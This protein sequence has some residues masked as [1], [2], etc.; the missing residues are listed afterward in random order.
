MTLISTASQVFGDCP[1]TGGG[2]TATSPVATVGGATVNVSHVLG[3]DGSARSF[4][5]TD[6]SPPS[7]PGAVTVN[8]PDCVAAG[9]LL[10]KQTSP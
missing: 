8:E 9:E 6:I 5:V 10:P 2:Y 7:S 1:P 3:A 4:E